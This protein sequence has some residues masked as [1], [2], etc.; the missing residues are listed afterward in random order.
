MSTDRE[1]SDSSYLLTRTYIVSSESKDYLKAE[2]ILPTA[3]ISLLAVTT[4][5]APAWPGFQINELG[6]PLDALDAVSQYFN[7]IA[8]KVST[9]RATK[10]TPQCNLDTAV[11]PTCELSSST[12]HTF[13]PLV[14]VLTSIVPGLPSP[15]DGTKLRHVAV[16]RG[17]Q[18]YTC[19]GSATSKPKAIGAV[20]TLFNVTCLATM[21]PD[22]SAKIPGMAVHF[23][24]DTANRL[25]PAVLPVSGHHLFTADGLPFFDLNT[26]TMQLGTLPCT[27]NASAN[28]PSTAAVG[29][30]GEPAVAWLRLLAT[31]DATG[32]LSEVFRVS[33]AGGSPPDTCKGLTGAFQVEYAA[34]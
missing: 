4:A 17:T 25:G 11:M 16:G 3:I 28:A 7:L 31:K 22:V 19:D 2:M 23:N 10:G 1:Y 13:R 32:G 14:D 24:L 21:Y 33:T 5:A 30:K 9:V 15:A 27:K 12:S 34:E 20:A 6:D 26:P 8:A 18:N 29:Q